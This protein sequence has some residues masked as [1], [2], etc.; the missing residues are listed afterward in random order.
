MKLNKL[1]IDDIALTKNLLSNETLK[2][3]NCKI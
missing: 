1:T 3:K 2:Q